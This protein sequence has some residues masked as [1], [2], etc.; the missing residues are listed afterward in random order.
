MHLKASQRKRKQ[1]TAHKLLV[2]F[3]LAFLQTTT[4][5]LPSNSISMSTQGGKKVAIVTGSNKGIG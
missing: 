2:S 3:L 1:T 5:L 4:A